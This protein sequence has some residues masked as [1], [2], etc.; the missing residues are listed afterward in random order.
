MLKKTPAAEAAG[1]KVR[2]ASRGEMMLSDNAPQ[3][4][5]FEPLLSPDEAAALAG[6]SVN[7]LARY[8][9][10]GRGPA[11]QSVGGRVF[12]RAADIEAWTGKAEG[13]LDTAEAAALLGFSERHLR[14][15]R[16]YGKG[17]AFV[18]LKGQRGRRA[19]FYR[20]EDVLDW[21]SAQ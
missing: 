12:Y 18:R 5:E 1:V 10:D 8:R 19:V 7:T 9:C 20:R 13:L 21:G 14:N 17:P 11:F 3:V 16:S 15:L 4:G 2:H 6:L